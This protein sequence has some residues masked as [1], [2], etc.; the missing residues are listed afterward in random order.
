ML[1]AGAL[2]V[3]VA[4][5][6]LA[7]PD[8]L[9]A[10]ALTIDAYLLTA[11]TGALLL[12]MSRVQRHQDLATQSWKQGEESRASREAATQRALDDLL[13]H[14]RAD[15]DE[16][17]QLRDA[18]HRQDQ[19]LARLAEATKMYGKPLVEI[20]AQTAQ[21]SD[22]VS[23]VHQQV[24]EIHPGG[25]A[26]A[27][28]VAG[29]AAMVTEM[30]RQLSE[31]AERLDETLTRPQADQDEELASSIRDV[32]REVGAL[33]AAMTRRPEA[34]PAPATP[35]ATTSGLDEPAGAAGGADGYSA[36]TR[37]SNSAG[38]LSAIAKLKQM[39][40]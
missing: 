17:L 19:E 35:T 5:V 20:A 15:A 6:G 22:T 2:C 13:A 10:E 1:A 32:Q 27:K 29:L 7:T 34:A 21:L 37:T 26:A 9:G 3:A 16:F 11:C 24:G 4:M 8:L 12:A 40:R 18:L 33:A 30:R 28:T 23:A 14:A 25:E 38:V 31:L 36:G 39:K